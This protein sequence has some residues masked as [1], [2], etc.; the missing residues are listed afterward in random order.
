[1]LQ[2]TMLLPRLAFA[3][4]LCT[5]SMIGSL[6]AEITRAPYLQLASDDSI[7]IVW[8]TDN[9]IAPSVKFGLKK[10]R[11]D[12]TTSSEDLIVR[13]TAADAQGLKTPP[14]HSAPKGTLQ[15]EAKLTGLR[16]DT[17]YHYAVYDGSK[18]QVWPG[19]RS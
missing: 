16:P 8:R 13:L 18:R 7:H 1:M 3:F 12:L 6:S 11:L 5:S 19:Q 15:F 14:L 2:L 17:L 9:S 4:I 10:G